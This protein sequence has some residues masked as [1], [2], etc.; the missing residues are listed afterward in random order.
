M[1][2]NISPSE[3]IAHMKMSKKRI[4]YMT[5]SDDKKEE[6]CAKKRQAYKEK[7]MATQQPSFGTIQMNQ[8]KGSWYSTLSLHKKEEI[9]KK[10]REAYHRKKNSLL[11]NSLHWPITKECSVQ[12]DRTHLFIDKQKRRNI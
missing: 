6:I 7:R 1:E 8:K 9:C 11:V 10:Q 2:H 4:C 5:L 12:S 3:D